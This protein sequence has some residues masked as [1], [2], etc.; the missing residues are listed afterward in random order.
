MAIFPSISWPSAQLLRHAYAVL[1]ATHWL[2]CF[3]VFKFWSTFQILYANRLSDVNFAKVFSYWV[4]VSLPVSFAA[5]KSFSFMRS[6]LSTLWAVFYAIGILLRKSLPILYRELF[7][8]VLYINYFGFCVTKLPTEMSEGRKAL[9]WLMV[10]EQSSAS[11]GGGRG[12]I[13]GGGN[14]WQ[15]PSACKPGRKDLSIGSR[16]RYSFRRLP[17]FLSAKPHHKTPAAFKL[18]PQT[19]DWVFKH[20][21][22]G[23]ILDSNHNWILWIPFSTGPFLWPICLSLA[24]LVQF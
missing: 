17:F 7:S 6:H 2:D 8:L 13:C 18:V 5:Q 20:D 23:N 16:N 4:V 24:Y 21:P 11:Q 9:L 19:G 1:L 3:V 15:S 10:S 14:I 12:R 22:V